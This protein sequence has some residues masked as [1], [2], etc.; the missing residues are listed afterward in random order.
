LAHVLGNGAGQDCDHDSRVA[1]IEKLEDMTD[2]AR[3]QVIE[4]AEY[5]TEEQVLAR[6][7]VLT[8]AELRRA[9]RANPPAI[10]FFAF[11]KRTGGPCCTPA[12]VQEY[13]N[14]FYLKDGSCQ[15]GPDRPS[16]SK[17]ASTTSI[18]PTPPGAASGTSAAMTPELEQFVAEALKRQILSRP[19]SRSRRSSLP[20]PKALDKRRLHLI[21]S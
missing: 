10:A 17:S 7:P 8:R 15:N 4:P 19:R 14:R 6:W 9:R 13:I 1:V 2:Q 11:H 20:H 5:L 21:K 3:Q 12:Q 18:S 16:D